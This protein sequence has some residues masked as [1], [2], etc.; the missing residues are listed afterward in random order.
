MTEPLPVIADQLA[1]EPTQLRLLADPLRSFIVYSTVPSAKSAKRLA[2]ELGCPV[3]RLYYHLQ[4]L[5]QAGFIRVEHTTTGKG[6]AEKHYRAA[7]RELLVRREKLAPA[8]G[9]EALD[10]LLGFVLD[11]SR[12]EIV[13]GVRDGRIDPQRRAPDP[14]ALVAWRN[15]LLLDPNQ[16]ARLY[17]RLQDFWMEYDEIAKHPPTDGQFYAFSVALYPNAAQRSVQPVP[18]VSDGAIPTCD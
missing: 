6:G 18:P 16:A 12:Q 13:E 17:Q 14:R 10:A 5:E 8:N 9:P 4:Q 7:A 3:T 1:I 2:A 15:V 11:Q